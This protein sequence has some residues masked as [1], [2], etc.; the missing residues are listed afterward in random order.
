MIFFQ[1]QTKTRKE[2]S[3]GFTLIEVLVSVS[4]FTVVAITGVTAV[5]AGKSAYEKNQAIKSATDSVAFIVE[6]ISKTA[7]LSAYYHCIPN[8]AGEVIDTQGLEVAQTGSDCKGLAYEPF[9]NIQQS[10]TEDDQVIYAFAQTTECENTPNPTSCG[11]LFSR[12]IPGDGTP[13]T[14]ENNTFQRLTPK[15]LDINITKSGFDVINQNGVPR[16]IVR[17]AGTITEKNETT[18][19]SLQTTISQRAIRLE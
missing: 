1:K 16:I 9:W 11:A 15:N 13:V 8:V 17:I 10:P 4:L 6:D 2:T 5:I 19:I 18:N 14:I 12:A 7:R 3:K